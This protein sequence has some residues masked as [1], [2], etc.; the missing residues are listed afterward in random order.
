M[1]ST[2]TKICQVQRLAHKCGAVPKGN[3]RYAYYRHKYW[4]LLDLFYDLI[5]WPSPIIKKMLNDG[6]L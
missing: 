6:D 2:D 3:P 5:G 1:K 4:Q